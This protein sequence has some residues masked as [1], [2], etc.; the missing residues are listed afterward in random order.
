MLLAVI[1]LVLLLVTDTASTAYTCAA[2]IA[3]AAAA[4]TVRL[5]S[6]GNY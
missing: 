6:Y 2:N 1:D 3:A 5:N 4:A